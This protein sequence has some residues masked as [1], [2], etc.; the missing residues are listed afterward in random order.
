MR[1][2]GKETLRLPETSRDKIL[3]IHVVIRLHPGRELT[4]REFTMCV[5]WTGSYSV[6]ENIH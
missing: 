3:P 2:P 4:G 6:W 1:K 5:Q